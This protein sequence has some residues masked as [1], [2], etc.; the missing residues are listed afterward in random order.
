MKK[1]FYDYREIS[2]S[3]PYA[4]NVALKAN[5]NIDKLLEDIFQEFWSR[6]IPI[7]QDIR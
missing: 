7:H 1:E 5:E 2:L 6:K 3:I 4:V